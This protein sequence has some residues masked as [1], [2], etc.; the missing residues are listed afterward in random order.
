M[1]ETKI[2]ATKW[3]RLAV[4][5]ATFNLI[6]AIPSGIDSAE[7]CEATL[8]CPFNYSQTDTLKLPSNIVAL[9]KVFKHC[10]PIFYD[11]SYKPGNID[12]IS[13]FFVVDHSG[14]MSVTDEN[15]I[16][17]ELISKLIDSLKVHS[18]ASEIG[19]A[20][21]SNQLLHNSDSD[22]YAKRL[23]PASGWTDSY[24]PL[25]RLNSTVGGKA[26]TD[27]LKSVIAMSPTE[28]D[29]GNNPKLVN[30][31]YGNSGRHSGQT[32]LETQLTG[33]NGT[34]DISL[35][36]DAARKAFQSAIYPKN[37]QYIIFLSD[38]EPQNVD[39]ERKTLINDYKKGLNLPTTFTAFWVTNAQPVPQ[40]ITEMTN[41]IRNNN[42]STT[43]PLSAVWKTSGNIDELLSKLLNISTG[44]GFSKIQSHPVNL[45]IN[46]VSALRFDDSLAVFENSI[47]L[48]N[49]LTNLD[50]SFT[51]HYDF[52][53]DIDSTRKFK[54]LIKSINS[55]QLPA[56]IFTT[57]WEQGTIHFFVNGK[58]VTGTVKDDDKEIEIRYFPQ[59]VISDNQIEIQVR[60]ASGSDSL[61]L[62]AVKQGSY[63]TKTF[64]RETASPKIDNLLQTENN[65]SIVGIYQNP[66]YPLDI[67]RSS[68]SIGAARDLAL[69]EAYYLDQDADG[70]PDVVRVVVG[71]AILAANELPEI[72]PYLYF[73]TG[74]ALSIKS[75][76]PSSVGFDIILNTSSE[77][78][79]FTGL[80]N[81]ERLGIKSVYGLPGGGGFPPTTIAI[82]DSMAPVI[83]NATFLNGIPSQSTAKGPD[84]L[85][86]KFSEKVAD[87]KNSSP[88]FL[89]DDVTTNKYK[90]T[91]TFLSNSDGGATQRF[92]VVPGSG[93]TEPSRNDSIWIDD[94]ASV[95]DLAENIQDNKDNHRVLLQFIAKQYN[96]TVVAC[97]TPSDPQKDLIPSQI[98]REM[99]GLKGNTGLVVI[100]KSDDQILA[101]DSISATISVYDQLGIP[102]VKDGICTVSSENGKL[103]YVWNG[104]NRNGRIV[105]NGTYV[106]IAKVKVTNGVSRTIKTKLGILHK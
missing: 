77:K 22:T 101:Q 10:S 53:M 15:S 34:T 31:Y 44:K 51:Y 57:C 102:V 17:Y 18:P 11:E 1:K 96:F 69:K 45:T 28:K 87:V 52:P 106:A 89:Y 46:N 20:I 84:T 41:A 55:A 49:P 8:N 29:I 38:G 86:V 85:V 62:T 6:V 59:G 68:R 40:Q 26:A 82:A 47:A 66:D 42:Y 32:G 90:I 54:V 94:K 100:I 71:S 37:K 3:S 35:A 58:E 79:R 27:Y 103:L 75:L 5:V 98:Q 92:L 36:F 88:F 70:Y 105:G 61:S 76:S 99:T 24:I 33:Y 95:R 23:D 63:F 74:R 12:T 48:Q 4:L 72:Q 91:L 13:L 16:R 73:T 14:S 39:L 30:C 65:D 78:E 50:I 9:S 25:T 60:N 64:T 97:P 19:M 67:V 104:A 83:V 2:N 93:N 43:N 81:N 56:D 80:Y 7:V 21:F